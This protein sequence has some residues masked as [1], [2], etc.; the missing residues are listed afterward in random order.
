MTID[1]LLIFAMAED[2]HPRALPW[3]QRWLS[4][5]E[6]LYVLRHRELFMAE[7]G[8]TCSGPKC[9][10]PSIH[11][12]PQNGHAY[13]LEGGQL[14][15]GFGFPK[16]SGKKKYRWKKMNFRTN[17]PKRAPLV[18]YI[19]ASARLCKKLPLEGEDRDFR[20]HVVIEANDSTHTLCH[21]REIVQP[22]RPPPPAPHPESPFQ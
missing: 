21:I 15:S 3:A 9:H 16:L 1:P 7:L 11:L 4:G 17:L 13:F 12:A 10:P 6:Y 8:F 18:T 2:S 20:M 22:P 5:E 14:G 19:V